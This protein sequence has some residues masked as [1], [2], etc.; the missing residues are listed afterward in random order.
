MTPRFEKTLKMVAV[1][2]LTLAIA[3]LF[4]AIAAPPQS[5]PTAPS[6]LTATVVSCNCIRLNWRDNSS[7]ESGFKIERCQGSGCNNFTQIAIVGANVTM[8]SDTA[9]SAGVSYSYRVRAYNAA[10]NSAYSN[11]ATATPSPS[12]CPSPTP[13]DTSGAE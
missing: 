7:N 11:T 9:V 8:Y 10:G 12:P 6:N 3:Y 5:P 1:L 13:G 4:S 2:L